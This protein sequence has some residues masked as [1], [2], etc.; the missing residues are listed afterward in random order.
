MNN[1][2]KIPMFPKCD[3]LQMNKFISVPFLNWNLS[4]WISQPF[5]MLYKTRNDLNITK[6]HQKIQNILKSKL[7]SIIVIKKDKC[8]TPMHLFFFNE[9][10]ILNNVVTYIRKQLNET[11]NSKDERVF[12]SIMQ[13]AVLPEWCEIVKYNGT[14]KL[15]KFLDYL[16]EKE[17]L[18]ISWDRNRLIPSCVNLKLISSFGSLLVSYLNEIAIQRKLTID[19]LSYGFF[20]DG[21]SSDSHGKGI[22]LDGLYLVGANWDLNKS[23]I[24]PPNSKTVAISKLPKCK[25]VP[26]EPIAKDANTYNCPVFRSLMSKEFLMKI[27]K[28]FLDGKESNLQWHIPLKTDVNEQQLIANSV[29]IV[30]Q[31]PDYF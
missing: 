6:V 4:R 2:D 17:D 16:K 27:D 19:A 20:F 18:L 22:V 28:V 7:P 24:I 25:F 8:V 9:I 12:N 30:Y 15:P 5:R 3:I 13:N 21:E 10:T 1:L 23:K 29:S 11:L 14:K 26:M 31:V